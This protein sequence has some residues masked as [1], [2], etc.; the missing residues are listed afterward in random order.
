MLAIEDPMLILMAIGAVIGLLLLIMIF[1]LGR[2]KK[3]LRKS[4]QANEQ[5][6]QLASK[7]LSAL[8]AQQVLLLEQ[9]SLLQKELTQNELYESKSDTYLQAINA[10]KSGVCAAEI[11][12]N[13]GLI[14]SEAELLVSVHGTREMTTD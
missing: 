7:S 4:L 9:N 2:H 5:F 11:T 13:Y 3:L 10:A 6:H 8:S 14:A 1:S 12:D